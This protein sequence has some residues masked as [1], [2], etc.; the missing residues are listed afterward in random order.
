MS[1]ALRHVRL[2]VLALACATAWVG[3]A[4][5]TPQTAGSAAERPPSAFILGQVVDAITGQPIPGAK[6]S[7]GDPRMM[8]PTENIVGGASLATSVVLTSAQG[9]FIFHDLR[10]GTYRILAVASGYIAGAVGQKAINGPSR[11]INLGD[12]EHVGDATIRLWKYASLS[13]RV[14]DEAGDPAVSVTVRAFR[15]QPVG[16]RRTL[17]SGGQAQTDE[18]GAFRIG[19]LIPG[20]YLVGIP[21]NT[22]SIPASL[23]DAYVAALQSGNPSAL[24]RDLSQSGG[25]FPSQSGM[26]VGDQVVQPSFP[27]GQKLPIA[28]SDD[29][30]H[31]L[32][33]PTLFYPSATSS[34]DASSVTLTSGQDFSGVEI[35]LRPMPSLRITGT[36]AGPDGPARNLGVRLIPASAQNLELD[37]NFESASSATDA[38]GAFTFLGVTAGQYVI[39]AQRLARP[40]G[41]GAVVTYTTTSGGST[42]ISSAVMPGDAASSGVA[43]AGLFA[44]LPVTVGD[45]DVDGVSLALRRGARVSGRAV[46]E[47]SAPQPNAAALQA[48]TVYLTPAAPG[49]S[50]SPSVRVGPDSQFVTVGSA[51]GRYFVTVNGTAPP[52]WSLQNPTFE[53]RNTDESPLDLQSDDVSGVVLQFTDQPTEVLG[54]VHPRAGGSAAEIQAAVIAFPA[55]LAAWMDRG[56]NTRRMRV[57]GVTKTGTFSL[58][59]LAPGEYLIA[60]VP[61]DAVGDA[62]DGKWLQALARV[63][64]RFTLAAHEKKSLDLSVS[65]PR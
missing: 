52:G 54:T 65:Q 41:P 8:G 21:A 2:G 50:T 12:G 47:G 27:Y 64:T 22:T 55:E 3:V 42:M 45:R 14:V 34:T 18:R 56:M 31:L 57:G 15:V 24:M 5:Q 32:I 44:Q 11:P 13:G 38:N 26:R 33:Y 61:A 35:Q 40:D 29:P 43:D 9:Q 62:R 20:E 30:T 28:A 19:G 36:I 59:N 23:S 25:V 48:L 58:S 39:R 1:T 51:P 7:L 4:G 60:A 63:A 17:A 53:G 49:A 16:T 37:N 6:V 10:K 46:F